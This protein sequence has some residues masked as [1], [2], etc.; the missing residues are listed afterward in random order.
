MKL[1]LAQERKYSYRFLEDMYLWYW[2][3]LVQ[4]ILTP[5]GQNQRKKYL[6]LF[7]RAFR[8]GCINPRHP[9]V[10]LNSQTFSYVDA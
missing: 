8:L 2:V 6:R 5:E 7:R 10:T 3:S 1:S 9:N 4:S